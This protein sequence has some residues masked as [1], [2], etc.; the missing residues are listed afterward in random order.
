MAHRIVRLKSGRQLGLTGIGNAEATRLALFLH[1]TPGAGGFD[2]DPIASNRH[3]LHIITIDRPGYGSSAPLPGSDDRASDPTIDGFV[4]DITEWLQ[5]SELI[6]RASSG[7]SYGSVGVIGWGSGGRYALALAEQHPGLVDRLVI[8]GTPAPAGDPDE[9]PGILDTVAVADDVS[10]ADVLHQL[11]GADL[12]TP[13]SLGISA[14]DRILEAPGL[15]LRLSRMLDD[16]AVQGAVGVAGDLVAKR[17]S[18]W[19]SR[20]G[21]VTAPTLLVYGSDDPIAGDAHAAWFA[22]RIPNAEVD[23]IADA[24]TLV[25]ASRWNRILDFLSPDDDPDDGP[26]GDSAEDGSDVSNPR[27]IADTD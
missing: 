9:L 24:G 7:I 25:V 5:T 21:D 27:G 6:A 18:A 26:G 4:T 2:P 17:D 15:A 23:L 1:P 16:A 19:T 13:R 11:D 14:D 3:D 22:E 12:T 20:L 8:V 10:L